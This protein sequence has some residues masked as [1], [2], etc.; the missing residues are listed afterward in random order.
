V[1]NWDIR[2]SRGGSGDIALISWAGV[3]WVIGLESIVT[4][5]ILFVVVGVPLSRTGWRRRKK[6]EVDY[7]T[8]KDFPSVV[9][10]S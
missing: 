1:T 9:V 3:R 10:L 7:E 8:W 2:S 4:K 5:W 6:T